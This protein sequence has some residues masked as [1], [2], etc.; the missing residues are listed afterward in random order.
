MFGVGSNLPG[1]TSLATMVRRHIVLI[2]PRY[3]TQLRILLSGTN[4][5]MAGMA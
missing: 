2:C 1:G 5:G 4:D 3:P